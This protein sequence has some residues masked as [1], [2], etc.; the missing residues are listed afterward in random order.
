MRKPTLSQLFTLS[1]IALAAALGLLWYVV[2]DATGAAIVESSEHV[3]AATSLRIGERVAGF[4]AQAPRAVRDFELALAGGRVR[5]REPD[6]LEAA[7]AVEL[8][9]SGDVG[10]LTLTYARRAGFGADGAATL[11]AAPRGQVSVARLRDGGAAP[12]P[13][14]ASSPSGASCRREAARRRRRSSPRRRTPSTTRRSTRPSRRRRA[15]RTRTSCS[16]ATSI[17]RSS[18]PRSRKSGGASR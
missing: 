10:E 1:L 13:T 8:R 11:D 12:H 5:A 4:L 2:V 17:G 18:T 14:A 9:S 7:L 6:D 16:G 15:A 3:R